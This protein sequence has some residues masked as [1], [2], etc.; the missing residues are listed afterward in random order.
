MHKLC[1]LTRLHRYGDLGVPILEV[2]YSV[3]VWFPTI[4]KKDKGMEKKEKI[5]GED[6]AEFD[7]RSMEEK[8]LIIHSAL[9]IKALR[10]IVDYYPGQSLLGDTISIKEPFSILVHYRK[11]LQEY[12]ESCGD[13]ETYH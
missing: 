6:K 5:D 8:E 11:E 12:R 3:T 2:L 9:I 13:A 4:Y 1:G 10:E 7:E